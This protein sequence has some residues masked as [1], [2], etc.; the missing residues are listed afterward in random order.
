MPIRYK[1]SRR[2]ILATVGRTAGAGAMYALMTQMGVARPSTFT[3]ELDLPKAPPGSSVLILGAGL[4]G[5]TAA[6]ELRKA[7]YEVKI[8]EYNE[9]AGGRCFTIRGGDTVTDL[10]GET[11]HC[12]FAEGNYFNPG[13]WRIP[14]NHHGVLHYCKKFNVKLEPFEGFNFNAYVHGQNTFGGKPKRIRE[15]LTDVQGHFAELLAKATDQNKLDGLFDADDRGLLLDRLDE[16]GHLTGKHEYAKSLE[17]SGYRGYD[18]WPG[19]GVDGK[20]T[21]S[22]PLDL[23]EILR[24]DYWWMLNSYV[25]TLYAP[26]LFEPVGGMDNIAR[27][28]E[29]EVGD[30]IE[31]QRKV[32]KISQ[33]ETGVTVYSVDAVR[34][35]SATTHRA[36]WCV[37]TIP[38]TILNQIAIDVSSEMQAAIGAVPYI[39]SVKTGLEFN[40]RF[41]EQDENIFGGITYT[42]LPITT[43]SYPS[44]G[45]FADG[46][47]VLLGSYTWE[48]ANSFT[49]SAMTAQQQID[50]AVAYGAKIHPQYLREFRS[51]VSW[52]W[53]RSPWTLGCAGDWTDEL[54]AMHYDNL[55]KIDNRLVLAGEHCSYLPAWQEGAILSAMDAVRRLDEKARS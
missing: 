48:T 8:L 39:S 18:N 13:P 20:P 43:I 54:R 47:A 32:V 1:P 16:W 41:W 50:M 7:G 23:G 27:G 5:M 36:D 31:Y 37:C 2:D 4:A 24:S 53:H 38:L 40:R 19:G 11:Q 45:Y 29:S 3:S 42:D 46:P 26:T 15:V 17:A 30:L 22:T 12:E 9:R 28:F 51:G 49:A 55:C 10:S 34:P 52:S 6:Y 14:Y 33:S 21:P 35:G 44:S 25:H